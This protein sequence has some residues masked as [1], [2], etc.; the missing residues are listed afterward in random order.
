MIR[1]SYDISVRKGVD[2]FRLRCGKITKGHNFVA[3][4]HDFWGGDYDRNIDEDLFVTFTIGY[5]HEDDNMEQCFYYKWFEVVRPVTPIEL[6]T[7]CIKFKGKLLKL[8][9]SKH[10]YKKI[11]DVAVV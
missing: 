7:G 8:N 3:Y 5:Y 2:N 9:N 1:K 4:A 6:M 11:D 10:C